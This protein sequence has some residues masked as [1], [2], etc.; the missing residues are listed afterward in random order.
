MRLTLTGLQCRDLAALEALGAVTNICSDKTGTLTQGAM[1]VRKVWLPTPDDNMFT[2]RDA[3][4]PNDPTAGRVSV[5]EAGA[6]SEETGASSEIGPASAGLGSSSSRDFDLLRSASSLKVSLPND[7]RSP[8][9]R[10]DTEPAEPDEP[11][12]VMTPDLRMFLLSSA[13]C[14]LATVR[15]DQQTQQ[16]QTIGEPTEIALQV[17]AKRFGLDKKALEAHGWQEV[18]EFP[19]DSTIKRMSVVYD[20]PADSNNN[21][22]ND[23]DADE[24]EQDDL[25]ITP[26]SSS[27]G[28]SNENSLVFTKGAVER[29]LDLC[30]TAGFGPARK[31]MTDELKAEMLQRMNALA[32][33]GLRVL[34]VAYRVWD[35]RFVP[36]QQQQQQRRRRRRQRESQESSRA[37]AATEG[38]GRDGDGEA[39]QAG[40]VD[41][42]VARADVERDL[43]LL[44]LVGIYD[45]PRKETARSIRACAEAGI[46]VHMLTGDHPATARAIA[47]E[48]GI[49]PRDL[50]VLPAAVASTA[51]MQATDFDG[52][53]DGEVDALE[54]LP[55]VIARCAPDTKTR[56][57]EALRRRGA[58]MAMTGD[59]VNDAPSLS[60][61]DVG[62]AMGSGSDVAKSA[63]KMV[64]V[65][66]KFNSIV[67]AVREGR[68]MF[69][70][71]QK[72]VLHL[73]VSN[74]G[75]VILL[76]LGLCFKD[77]AGLSVFPVSPL[78]I[79]WINMLTSSFPAFGLGREQAAADIMRKPPHKHGL[80]TRQIMADMVVCG[81][82]MGACSLL[83]FVAVV[84]GLYGGRLGDDCNRQWSEA[85]EPVFRAR[86]AVFIELSWLILISAWEFK[87]LR[88]SMFR[89]DPHSKK[90]FPLNFLADMWANQFLFWA[91]A[92]GM[93][94][95][96]P[97]VYIPVLNIEFL[98]QAPI[99][100]EWVFVLAGF[101]I[102]I[103][104]VEM[105]KY[106]KRTK[107][108]FLEEPPT[109]LPSAA[110]PLPRAPRRPR[111][112][113]PTFSSR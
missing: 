52:M 28:S 107:G 35:G 108:W 61:A 86:S 2:L 68:R 21:S 71:V 24:R 90:A 63:A 37:R 10:A 7:K 47:G 66:D 6:T 100:V 48:V 83:T 99:T 4:N 103:L 113:G 11:D 110:A 56:M 77:A 106:G 69:D 22:S 26:I 111:P 14:N 27:G 73:L 55:L 50:G 65:D 18:A 45:P 62:I 88:R 44:G 40:Q 64:L 94:V 59:G 23:S 92:G 105:W 79:L 3:E 34:A 101:V 19:F 97:T 102:F 9:G 25:A 112:R 74:V 49:V 54:E 104:T 31:P 5:S 89:L 16:W 72:F 84:Y 58:F 17:F 109:P 93:A 29:I 38:S 1:I 15:Q 46:K 41:A 91:V 70:N 57:I 20:G 51:V 81:T 42:A 53:T 85:C 82:V 8:G 75:E 87:H 30:S 96:P 33:L 43:C 32:S 67:A 36:Q 98:K 80:F 78:Q 39:G 76:I 12:A 60:R 13:L 95:I